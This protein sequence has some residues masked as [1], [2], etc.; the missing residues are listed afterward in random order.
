MK[1]NEWLIKLALVGTVLLHII[2]LLKLNFFPYPELFVYTYLTKIGMIPY[3]QIIDQHFPGLIF[4]PINLATI[5]IDSIIDYRVVQLALVVFS[6]I[7]IF[8]IGKQLLKNNVYSL[9]PNLLY[10]IWQPFFEGHVLWIDSFV[11]PILLLSLFFLI[12]AKNRTGY[13]AGGLT[14]GIGIVVKQVTAPLLILVWIYTLMHTRHKKYTVWLSLGMLIPG[15]LMCMYFVSIGVWN[16]FWY[17][18]VIFNLTI[19]SELGRKYASYGELVRSFIVFG[20][21]I[22]SSILIF[23]RNKV[24]KDI[25][26]VGIFMLATLMFAYARFDYVHLQPA[27]PFAIILITYAFTRFEKKKIYFTAYFILSFLVVFQPIKS[28]IGTKT[29]FF[30]DFEKALVSEISKYASQNDSVFAMATTPHI[31][32]MSNTH[33]PGNVFV[34]H[35]DWFMRIAEPKILNGI[36]IDP[37]KVILRDK[38]ASVSDRNLVEY[39]PR[40]EEYINSRYTIVNKIG[41]VEVLIP[42]ENS[43]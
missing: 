4:F 16:D 36:R 31:Y 18:T 25:I 11:V 41:S 37:P 7:L 9:I 5:G 8:A 15:I 2:I 38:E 13:F 35:F 28:N 27:L 20:V 32:Y 24:D 33:P 43:N 22:L 1:K 14:L 21:S 19:F 34:F 23:K 29:H 12:K 40:I 10:T 6:H 42:N 39:M 30:T 26:L 3:G 17:W